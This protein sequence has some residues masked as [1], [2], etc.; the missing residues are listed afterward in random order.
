MMKNY[1][2]LYVLAV[3][4]TAYAV[5]TAQL[6]PLLMFI[7]LLII[8]LI[9]KRITVIQLLSFL[10][11]IA[12]FYHYFPHPYVGQ[13]NITDSE[14]IHDT[15]SGTIASSPVKTDS[16]I[17]FSFKEEQTKRKILVTYFIPDEVETESYAD[18]MKKLFY[19]NNCSLTGTLSLP[20]RATNPYQFDYRTYLDEKG[21]SYVLHVDTLAD[22]SCTKT[23]PFAPLLTLRQTFIDQAMK[24]YSEDVA[25]W[26]QA[27]VLGN[28]SSLDDET[29]ELFQ[30]WSLSHILAISGLHV[31][32]I[33]SMLYILLMRTRLFTVEVVESVLLIFLPVYALLAGGAPSV[34]RASLMIVV[35]LLLRKS[36][37]RFNYTDIVSIVFIVLVF[38]DKY[39][40]FDVGFQLSF[41]VTY[42]LLFSS[43]LIRQTESNLFRVLQISFISQMAILPLQIEYFH[44]FQPLSIIVNLIVVPYFSFFV[45]PLMFFFFL[46]LSVPNFITYPLEK[47]FRFIHDHLLHVLFYIDEHIM[48]PYIIGELSLIEMLLYYV[49]FIAMMRTLEVRRIRRSFSY[50]ILLVGVIVFFAIRPYLSPVGVVT[51]LDIGQGDAIVIELPYRRGVFFVD[52]GATVSFEQQK[53]SARIF[54][55]IIRPYLYGRGIHKIDAIFLSHEHLDHIGSVSYILEQ[56]TVD[57]IIVPPYFDQTFIHGWQ[58]ESVTITE[59]AIPSSIIRKKHPFYVLSPTKDFQSAN[60]NSLVIWTEFGNKS[61][62]FTGDM[63]ESAERVLLDLF[64]HIAFDVLKVAHHGSNTSTDRE[65]VELGNPD[66]ALISVGENNRYGHPAKDV[67]DILNEENVHI[68]RTDEVGAIQ[69]FFT[70]RESTFVPFLQQNE[71]KK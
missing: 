3:V 37:L 66:V 5:K 34:W 19:S 13:L 58:E 29:V 16:Y 55:Q 61:W 60:D 50:G 31:G 30:R 1:Y 59:A 14:T 4:L 17:Q 70:E 36:D 18:E 8:L 64:P 24:N 62:L 54:Q 51:M 27:L 28:R 43:K 67:L 38:I 39:I 7:V 45:I 40:I 26:I 32:I 57:E 42:S 12:F 48:Y 22:I 44:Y 10:F 35:A 6:Y 71:R 11:L 68:F 52:A 15:F 20:D 2:Y 49:V 47:L 41:A 63:E 33:T 65:I 23:S 21:I 9:R 46:T 69:F 56:F 53:P 25:A